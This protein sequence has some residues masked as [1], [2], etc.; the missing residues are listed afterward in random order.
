MTALLNDRD[1]HRPRAK[2]RLFL[3][4]APTPPLK[5]S[6]KVAGGAYD[7]MPVGERT[8]KVIEILEGTRLFLNV[9]EVY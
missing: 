2:E 5:I 9:D 8:R 7:V 3:A 6:R 1:Y 4:G